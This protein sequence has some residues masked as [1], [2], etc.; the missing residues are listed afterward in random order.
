[1]SAFDTEMADFHA[2]AYIWIVHG[3]ISLDDE[4]MHALFVTDKISPNDGKI[5]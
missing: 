1:M 5:L 2:F 4:Y 3:Y